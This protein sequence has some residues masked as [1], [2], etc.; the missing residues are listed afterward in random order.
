MPTKIVVTDYLEPDFNWEKDQLRSRNVDFSW[1][2]HQLKFAPADDLVKAIGDADVV[3]VNMAAMNAE[4]IS[5]LSKCRLI[6]RHGI[7]YDNVDLKAAT[8]KG[9]RVANIPDYCPEEVAEQAVMLIFA[10]ARHLPEQLISMDASMAK[11]AWDFS[12]VRSVYMMHGKTLGIV[13]CGRIGRR[14]LRMAAGFGMK[15]LVC[16]PY[17]SEADRQELGLQNTVSLETVL[18]ESDIVTLHTP[19]NDETR[20][21]INAGALS[22]MKRSAV[23]V[24]TARGPLIVDEDLAEALQRGVIARAAIDVYHREPPSRETPL[25]KAPNLLMTPHLAWYS[26]ESVWSIR[27]KILE[28]IVLFLEGK[29]PRFTVN[30]A[31]EK[32]IAARKKA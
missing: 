6:I 12:P 10:A 7:G 2:E 27:E 32:V 19:L 11:G 23:L 24:N 14:V 26:E 22:M 17:L 13:G 21:M 4:V 5:R 29:P 20:G 18:K 30:P 28:N 16:D 3:V 8:A 15:I 25:A 1:Q 9:I 31:V